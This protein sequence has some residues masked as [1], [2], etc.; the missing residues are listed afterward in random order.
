M[1]KEIISFSETD[2]SDFDNDLLNARHR[3]TPLSKK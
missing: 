3:N 2:D 1:Q